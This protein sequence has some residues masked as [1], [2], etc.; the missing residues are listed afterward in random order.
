MLS[1]PAGLVK[2]N[3]GQPEAAFLVPY[4][5]KIR[6]YYFTRTA[7]IQINSPPAANYLEAYRTG[8]GNPHAYPVLG[9]D[10][11]DIG[12]I[13]IDFFSCTPVAFPAKHAVTGKG[14]LKGERVSAGR[15][16]NNG[17]GA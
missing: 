16:K 14:G 13:E 12:L 2:F 17:R 8:I 3:H 15:R 4:P 7:Y 5:T 9:L 1:A 11:L 6:H 10:I